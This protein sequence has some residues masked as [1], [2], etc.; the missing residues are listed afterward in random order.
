MILRVL[1][2]GVVLLLVIRALSV[3]LRGIAVGSSHAVRE[4]PSAPPVKLARDPVC[5]THVSPRSALSL[6]SRGQTHYF[7]SEECRQKFAGG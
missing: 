3:L 5:G 2:I 6:A 7:C 4:G 1:L